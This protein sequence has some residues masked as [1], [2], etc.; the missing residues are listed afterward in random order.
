MKIIAKKEHNKFSYYEDEHLI[1]TIT[2][3]KE[4]GLLKVVLNNQL[5]KPFY[6]AFQLVSWKDRFRKNKHDYAI[7]ED[8]RKICELIHMKD[9]YEAEYFATML[10]FEDCLE[11]GVKYIHVKHKNKEVAKYSNQDDLMIEIKNPN[12]HAIHIMLSF[13][14]NL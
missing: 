5:N 7:Y 8:E 1:Y 2:S 9:G 6:E 3:M 4:K 11:N 14:L 13:L 12:D 10:R